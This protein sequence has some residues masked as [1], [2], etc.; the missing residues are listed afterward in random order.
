MAGR[1]IE[2]LCYNAEATVTLGQWDEAEHM[3]IVNKTLTWPT[4]PDSNRITLMNIGQ[5]CCMPT[6]CKNV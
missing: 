6:S 4:T 1:N 2:G 3:S 5:L